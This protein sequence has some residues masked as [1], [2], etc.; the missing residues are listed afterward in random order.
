MILNPDHLFGNNENGNERQNI[1]SS[2][3]LFISTYPESKEILD[4]FLNPDPDN[5]EIDVYPENQDSTR[6][7]Q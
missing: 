4:Y 5:E 6:K 1:W 7:N 2:L 3:G